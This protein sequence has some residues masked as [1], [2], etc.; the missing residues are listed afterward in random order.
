MNLFSKL[1]PLRLLP[2]LVL[3]QGT[4]KAVSVNAL[5]QSPYARSIVAT[6]AKID[7]SANASAYVQSLCNAPGIATLEGKLLINQRIVINAN[8]LTVTGSATIVVGAGIDEAFWADGKTNTTIKGLTFIRAATN[9]GEPVAARFKQC[10][11]PVFSENYCYGV[12]GPQTYRPAYTGASSTSLCYDVRFNYNTIKN[13][14]SGPYGGAISLNFVNGAQVIGNSINGALHGIMWWGGDGNPASG[15]NNTAGTATKWAKNL[16]ISYNRVLN[17]SGGSIWGSMG[18]DISGTDNTAE[19]AGDVL[20]DCEASRNVSFTNSIAKHGLNSALATFYGSENI[21]FYNAQVVQ[22]DGDGN[23]YRDYGTLKS[24]KVTLFGGSLLTTSTSSEA[25]FCGDGT[26]SE[27]TLDGPL[28]IVSRKTPIFLQRSDYLKITPSVS[29]TF[30]SA[31]ADGNRVGIYLQGGTG[32]D[33]NGVSITYTGSDTSAAIKLS[34]GGSGA[35]TNATI[36]NVVARGTNFTYG[37]INDQFG[38]GTGNKFYNNTLPTISVTNGSVIQQ[39]NVNSLTGLPLPGNV[40][41]KSLDDRIKVLETAA[42]NYVPTNGQTS[43]GGG[44]TTAVVS[45]YNPPRADS[46]IGRVNLATMTSYTATTVSAFNGYLTS[47]LTNAHVYVTTNV[48][49]DG[50]Y[51]QTGSLDNVIFEGLGDAMVAGAGNSVRFTNSSGTT[52]LR[53]QGGATRHNWCFKNFRFECT[54]VQGD[55]SGQYPVIHSNELPTHDGGELNHLYITCP[56]ANADAIGWFQYSTGS[57]QGKLAKNMIV[58]N[59]KGENLGRMFLEVLSQGYDGVERIYNWTVT[60]NISINSGT[61]NPLYGQVVSFSGLG[62][63]IYIARNTSTGHKDMAHEIANCH[64]AVIEDNSI[65]GAKTNSNGTASIG[66]SISDDRGTFSTKGIVVRRNDI[67]VLGR[68]IQVYNTDSVYV[69]PENHLWV[70]HR[71]IDT[72]NMTHSLWENFNLRIWST[73]SNGESGLQI[74]GGGN[75]NTFRNGTVS[76]GGATAAGYYP[77]WEQMVF[78]LS[79]IHI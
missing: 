36:Q 68:A 19:N 69:N 10:T 30:S 63:R 72:G 23:S 53:F 56:N 17:V 4:K 33:I 45:G 61:V 27:L 16:K 47:N 39:G 41:I 28:R 79:L 15:E 8:N 48:V 32:A 40:T 38:G 65:S 78:R 18:E 7:G 11:G 74:A 70:S 21:N 26:L 77:S 42:G 9:A 62:Q 5:R 76:S 46:T 64:Y 31:T 25:I 49:M 55:D 57:N 43:G 59:C 35:I 75:Y 50:Y 2:A 66:I 58:R 71:Q 37:I 54:A 12:L 13:V 51:E 3:G 60:N 22:S 34:D 6:D 29:I 1:L 67:D 20:F 14:G 24:R 44:S 73:N 52:L